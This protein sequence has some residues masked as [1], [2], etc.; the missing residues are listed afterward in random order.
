ML[1]SIDK[2]FNEVQACKR[3]IDDIVQYWEDIT[4]YSAM[5][6]ESKMKEYTN[7]I[8]IY[9]NQE[10]KVLDVMNK[11]SRIER[12]SI[13]VV[14]YEIIDSVLKKVQEIY[15]DARSISHTAYACVYNLRNMGISEFKESFD[16]FSEQYEELNNRILSYYLAYN[17]LH[18]E[19]FNNLFKI[20][21]PR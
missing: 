20:K 13:E 16:M 3:T 5:P 19:N 7:L 14:D 9:S 8:E 15:K 11:L 6:D 17:A 12:W 2:Q 1:S 4:N 10:S 21:K 18:S